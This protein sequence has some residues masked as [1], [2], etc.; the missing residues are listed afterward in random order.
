MFIDDQT[1]REEKM[2][3]KTQAKLII[4]VAVVDLSR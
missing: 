2:T 1:Y 4:G 3:A